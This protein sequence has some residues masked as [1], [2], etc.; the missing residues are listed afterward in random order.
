M[1]RDIIRGFFV[2]SFF[3]SNDLFKIIQINDKLFNFRNDKL[4]TPDA[5]AEIP[6]HT[7][8]NKQKEYI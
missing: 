8:T 6:K 7:K 2:S 3:L 1:V 5:I 4:I